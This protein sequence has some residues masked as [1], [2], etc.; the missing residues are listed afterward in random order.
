MAFTV[1][2]ACWISKVS[3]FPRE[4][5]VFR[6]TKAISLSHVHHILHIACIKKSTTKVPYIL[7]QA[8][9]NKV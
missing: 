9:V 7:T 3:L 8:H 4:D 6:K 2:G 1:Q 5:I